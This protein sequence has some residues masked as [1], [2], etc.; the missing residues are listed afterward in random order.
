[1]HTSK[2]AADGRRLVLQ[3]VM[4]SDLSPWNPLK[5][6]S[7]ISFR[8]LPLLV[9]QN[10]A[11]MFQQTFHFLEIIARHTARLSEED[12]LNPSSTEFPCGDPAPRTYEMFASEI[13]KYG[14]GG[15]A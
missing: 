2:S 3:H 9:L 13:V 6:P 10:A 1:M 4:I 14:K 12:G 7:A 5:C 15:K 8:K 11:L